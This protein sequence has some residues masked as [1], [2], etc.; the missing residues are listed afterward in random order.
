[1]GLGRDRALD[2]RVER[3]EPRVE[4]APGETEGESGAVA[5]ADVHRGDPRQRLRDGHGELIPTRSRLRAA[6]TGEP[7]LC[8]GKHFTGRAEGILVGAVGPAR[9][10]QGAE[11][12]A[13]VAVHHEFDP[14]LVRA[15]AR[16][17]RQRGGVDDSVDAAQGAIEKQERARF[18]ARGREQAGGEGGCGVIGAH[19]DAPSRQRSA[20]R[21]QQRGRPLRARIGAED[22]GAKEDPPARMHGEPAGECRGNRLTE[23]ES[24]I[25]EQQRATPE[26]VRGRAGVLLEGAPV[27]HAHAGAVRTEAFEGVERAVIAGEGQGGQRLGGYAVTPCQGEPSGAGARRKGAQGRGNPAECQP[28]C[29]AQRSRGRAAINDGHGV[30]TAEGFGGVCES[31]RSGAHDD[32]IPD[33][34]ARGPRCPGGPAT[35][36]SHVSM[37]LASPEACARTRVRPRVVHRSV[38]ERSPTP[39]AGGEMRLA[40]RT[41]A[42]ARPMTDNDAPATGP[43]TAVPTTADKTE[44]LTGPPPEDY[45]G[46]EAPP[47]PPIA[48]SADSVSNGMRIAAAWSW[49]ILL[50]LAMVAVLVYLVVQLRIIV[51]PVL[52]AVLLGSLLV[53]FVAFLT[54]HRWPRGLAI[55]TAMLGTIVVISGLLFLAIRQIASQSH[56]LRERAV[57]G[58]VAFKAFL[59]DSPLHLS[60]EQISQYLA[61]AMKMLQEDS[62]V[63]VSGALSLGTTIGHVATGAILALFTLLFV[64]IDGRG[65]WHWI[66]RLFPRSAR[67]AVAG[68]GEAGWRTLTSY[69]RTQVLVASI[70]AVGIGIGAA[71]FA[72]PVAIPI[73]VLVFLG[74]FVP[75]VGAVVTGIV[76]VVVALLLNGWVV[77]LWMLIVVLGVQQLEGHILQPLIMGTAVKVHPLAVVLAVA[78]G[79]MLAGIPGALFA[80]PV[81]AVINIMVRYI[82]GG[83]WKPGA[84]GVDP[85]GGIWRTVPYERRTR[86]AVPEGEK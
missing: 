69:A 47:V 15:A 18:R 41:R 62:Q 50:V 65:M 56:V 82:A 64:L 60:E 58:F 67:P 52:V 8:P 39:L 71:F 2:G 76:A 75:I 13:A 21:V 6:L 53:P 83:A 51:V 42:Y 9:R 84:A 61:D 14:R 45:P 79:S 72:T 1:M 81:A 74:S 34:G 73:A 28:P 26:P 80:V 24:K 20:T 32:E 38:T 23:G 10:R 16:H 63:L 44:L 29:A 36:H 33:R 46:A 3:G 85:S 22:F 35:D 30:S 40:P 7:E 68:A 78:A 19:D 5:T 59:K 54:R 37:F 66:V 77:A 43:E 86:H 12:H 27:E 11:E 25:I 55:A 17:T 48:R 31:E 49:R 4:T 70:D 57:E